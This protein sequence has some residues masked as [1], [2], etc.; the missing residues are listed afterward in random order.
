MIL[1]FRHEYSINVSKMLTLYLFI[2]LKI[3]LV[4]NFNCYNIL[5]IEY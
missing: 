1:S 3:L 4:I 2:N 5:L